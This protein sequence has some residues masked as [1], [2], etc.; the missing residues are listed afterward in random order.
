MVAGQI[1]RSDVTND[2]GEFT[3]RPLPPGEYEVQ[4]SDYGRDG[5]KEGRKR[6]GVPGVFLRHKVVL[7]DD[8]LTVEIRESPHVVIEAQYYDSKGKKGR[9]HG[10]TIFGQIDK[11]FWHCEARVNADGKMIVLVP[12]GLEKARLSLMTNEHGSLRFRKSKGAPLAFGR[13]L[14]LG[15]LDDDVRGIEIIHYKAPMVVVKVTARDGQKPAKVKLS[16]TYKNSKEPKLFP[17]NGPPTHIFFEHQED[18]RFHTSQL[19]PDEDVDITAHAEGYKDKIIGMRLP[20][21]L[22][23]EVE[24]VLDR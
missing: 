8:P 14:D 19:V 23:R 1:N 6:Y 3:M 20:E 22:V 12:H 4:P 21:G 16:G 9:G 2:K 18:G 13:D 17:V 7:K 15:T 11:S 10:G 24:I 5:S